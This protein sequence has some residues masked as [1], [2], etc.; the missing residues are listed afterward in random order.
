M[1]NILYSNYKIRNDFCFVETRNL[2]NT[3][4][5]NLGNTETRNLGN[6]ET[7]KLGNS[8]TRKLGNTE[9]PSRPS[10]NYIGAPDI[11][12]SRVP[13]ILS[14]AL[15]VISTLYIHFDLQLKLICLDGILSAYATVIK[16]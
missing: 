10:Y 16:F 15:D 6:T 14:A 1:V 11:I 7:R 8:E 12:F 4:T 13:Q 9:V 5:Q 3:E 2:G